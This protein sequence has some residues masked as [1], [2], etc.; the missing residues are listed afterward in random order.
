MDSFERAADIV[1]VVVIIVISYIIIA[2]FIMR[3][4]DIRIRLILLNYCQQILS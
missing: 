2:G 4:V 3:L 1:V